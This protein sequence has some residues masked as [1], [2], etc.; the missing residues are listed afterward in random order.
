MLVK[1]HDSQTNAVRLCLP[2]LV[3]LID[4]RYILWRHLFLLASEAQQVNGCRSMVV[5]LSLSDSHF[6]LP[7]EIGCK[8]ESSVRKSDTNIKGTEGVFSNPFPHLI[9]AM[10]HLWMKAFSFD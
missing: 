9:D 2:V 8:D 6:L 10:P 5:G 4:V 1:H 7:L 3:G